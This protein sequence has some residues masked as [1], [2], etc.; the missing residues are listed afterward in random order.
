MLHSFAPTHAFK[1]SRAA[2]EEAFGMPLEQAFEYF[3]A[4][5]VAS[6]SI[7]QV[8]SMSGLGTAGGKS[9]GPAPVR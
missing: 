2:V 5:P 1:H 4:E 8:R 3:E 9:L 6:G 7:A